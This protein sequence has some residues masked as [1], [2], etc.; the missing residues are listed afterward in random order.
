MGTMNG[1]KPWLEAANQEYE[2]QQ[3]RP[4][5]PQPEETTPMQPYNYDS[6][7][8]ADPTK[9]RRRE[10]MQSEEKKMETPNLAR[11]IWQHVKHG[12]WGPDDIAKAINDAA[13]P[14]AEQPNS[15]QIEPNEKKIY[16]SECPRC[17]LHLTPDYGP[18][19]HGLVCSAEQRSEQETERT[20]LV[21]RAIT[22]LH[23]NIAKRDIGKLQSENAELRA[24]IA[25]MEAPIK[26][27]YWA[28]II[29]DAVAQLGSSS[30]LMPMTSSLMAIAMACRSGFT[31]RTLES[32]ATSNSE[33]LIDKIT[34]TN[35]HGDAWASPSE[36]LIANEEG[37]LPCPFCGGERIVKCVRGYDGPDRH[38]L[39]C[40]DCG[41][42]T[43][44]NY[45]RTQAE[46]IAAW[47]R[48]DRRTRSG[49]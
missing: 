36:G 3:E 26:I 43:R 49:E 42:T 20:P 31:P 17:G 18:L 6:G 35:Q 11:E 33:Q 32:S 38:W 34:D 4:A 45:Y 29:E 27:E 19:Q 10:E 41:A 24:R 5:D 7:R 47:N 48:R 21:E 1:D 40:C 8:F 9:D 22:R 30:K 39:K 16:T 15:E 2:R 23:D 44:Q 13:R 25:A 37:L 12:Q 14:S 46:A 28:R